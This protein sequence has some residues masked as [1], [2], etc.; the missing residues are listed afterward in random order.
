MYC[1]LPLAYSS[2]LCIMSFKTLLSFLK[3]FS[4]VADE[5]SIFQ[6]STFEAF[7]IYTFNFPSYLMN[8][9]GI[10]FKV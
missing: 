4:R 6:L 2:S 3:N 9:L 1:C 5:G 7:Y 8:S 10:E